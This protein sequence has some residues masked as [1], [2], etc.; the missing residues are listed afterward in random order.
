MK[1]EI[2]ENGTLII[3]SETNLESY[4]IQKWIDENFEACS[5][6]MKRDNILFNAQSVK[7]AKKIRTPIGKIEIVSL[8]YEWLKIPTEIQPSFDSFI[9]NCED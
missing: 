2:N 6:N 8:Y 1:A 3:S 5:K 7:E 4:A 9:M